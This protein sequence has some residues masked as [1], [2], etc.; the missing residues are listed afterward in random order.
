MSITLDEVP[1]FAKAIM[2]RPPPTV[3]VAISVLEHELKSMNDFRTVSRYLVNRLA[4]DAGILLSY[5]P[6][7]PRVFG[8]RIPRPLPSATVA[9]IRRQQVLRKAQIQGKRAAR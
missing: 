7:K 5:V 4:T 9:D 1:D 2:Q 3:K 8:E 6:D